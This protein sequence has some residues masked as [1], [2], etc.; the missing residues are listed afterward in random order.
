VRQMVDHLGQGIDSAGP[1]SPVEVSGLDELPQAGDRFYAVQ[2]IEEAQQ[3]TDARRQAA[4]QASLTFSQPKTLQGLLDQIQAGKTTELPIILKADVQGS[5]EALASSIG[6]LGTDEI[7]VKILH[8]AVGGITAGDVMLAEASSAI[9]IGF[10]VVADA[11]ARQLAEENTVDI[12]TYRIIYEVIDDIRAALERGLA[13]EIRMETLGRADVRQVF[14][15][16][17]VGTIAGCMVTDGVVSRSAR[18]RIVRNNVVLED[19]R[20]LESL[21]RF[22]DDVREVRAGMECGLKVAG[23]DDLKEG[24]SLEFYQRI[25]VARKL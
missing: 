22:K 1:S 10:N 24:D 19:D 7:R 20:T 25:E 13:P 15:V 21:K 23:Y 14:K 8:A 18:V 9:I 12:R 5:A 17:R 11:A 4:R 2:S 3:V 16:S 6:K